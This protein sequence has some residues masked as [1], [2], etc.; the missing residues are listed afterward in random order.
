MQ[1]FVSGAEL[2]AALGIG[3]AGA[4]HCLGMCGG[5]STALGLGGANA[6]VSWSYQGGRLLSYTLLGALA[7]LLAGSLDF[8]A[9]GPTLRSLA[10]LL[11]IGMGLYIAN[12]WHGI[13]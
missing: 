4:G 6:T 5:V 12:W 13:V 10:G 8:S 3:L 9:A 1:G 11:M 2:L 7:G